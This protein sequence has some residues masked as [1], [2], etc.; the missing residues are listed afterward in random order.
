MT[1]Q[2]KSPWSGA[3]FALTF[4]F[5]MLFTFYGE[6]LLHANSYLFSS[7]GDGMKNYFAL[8]FHL[9]HDSDLV[10]FQ[11]MNYPF[12]DMMFY[13]D[14]N[15]LLFMI[16]D[17]LSILFPRVNEYAV[18][19]YNISVLLSLPLGA[20]FISLIF[21]R[22]EVHGWINGLFSLAII[23]F[24]PQISRWGGHMT[25]GYVWVIPASIHFMLGTRLN[26]RK[27]YSCLGLFV[28]LG[29]A[30]L[31]HPYLAVISAA[32][33]LATLFFDLLKQLPTT[34]TSYQLPLYTL[35]GTLAPLFIYMVSIKL[36]D[37]FDGRSTKPFGFYHYH[38]EL[39]SVFLPPHG[40]IKAFLV[41]IFEFFKFTYSEY[42]YEGISY[43]GLV[44]VLFCLV[45]IYG[46]IRRKSVFSNPLL[47]SI[48]FSSILLLLFA[49]CLPFRFGGV[50]YKLADSV[51]LIRQFRGL[52]RFA[53]P[54]TYLTCMFSLLYFYNWAKKSAQ[55]KRFILPV[56][57]ALVVL[58]EA[59]PGH[60]MVSKKIQEGENSFAHLPA[61]LE[62][63]EWEQ[64]QSILSVPAFRIGSEYMMHEVSDNHLSANFLLSYHTGLP[65][66]SSMMGRTSVPITLMQAQ[67]LEPNVMDKEIWTHLNQQK[68]FLLIVDPSSLTKTEQRL[69]DR[70][71]ALGSF[72]GHA[73]YSLTYASL[74]KDEGQ[75]YS[76]AYTN[77]KPCGDFSTSSGG[78]QHVIF[79]SFKSDD[80]TLQGVDGNGAISS[81][82]DQY[83]VLTSFEKDTLAPGDYEVSIWE[84]GNF[85]SFNG[86]LIVQEKLGDQT[87]WTEIKGKTR[88]WA[89][90]GDWHLLSLPFEVKSGASYDILVHGPEYD[91]S[92]GTYDRL[93]IRPVGLDV[94]QKESGKAWFNNLEIGDEA[95]F[96]FPTEPDSLSAL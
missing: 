94:F 52:G 79:D 80:N 50:F 82:I 84:K 87:N 81:A 27:L 73:L 45:F 77:S 24:S 58:L 76:T 85:N 20:L 3:L 61:E 70:G 44:G 1:F 68:N 49:L 19:I 74:T 78:C 69:V 14:G 56:V 42:A 47:G 43:I 83:L 36:L 95:M 64:Y 17:S 30:F 67:L 65:L 28:T 31:L 60:R 29:A 72:M 4:T 16:L 21:H 6:V 12:G 7:T 40:P 26:S 54:F 71:A 13:T 90:R 41:P 9:K 57:L 59:L 18:G 35:I 91:K 8:L 53:W 10:H 51:D 34:L 22:F 66:M 88:F 62:G 96:N 2:S 32:L 33:I 37:P 92:I 46:S 48:F 15:P 86:L 39:G 55:L 11:G 25:L 63:M 93:M 89:T 38:A 75:F 23:M 5:I